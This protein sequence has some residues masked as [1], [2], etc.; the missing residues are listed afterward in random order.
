M[1]HNIIYCTNLILVKRHTP[2]GSYNMSQEDFCNTSE[3]RKIFEGFEREN[4]RNPLE[5]VLAA[6]EVR[7]V[8]T[9]TGLNY[10]KALKKNSKDVDSTWAE[11]F[12]RKNTI[13]LAKLAKIMA[14]NNSCLSVLMPTESVHGAFLR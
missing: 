12:F 5:V 14:Q 10:Q 9:E 4:D 1:G 6:L 7:D 2:T 13:I 8:R 11:I 3:G